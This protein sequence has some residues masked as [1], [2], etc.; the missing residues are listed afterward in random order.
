MKFTA[1]EEYGLRCLI[2]MAREPG[3]LGTIPEIARQEGLTAAYVA[4]LMRVLRRAGLVESVRGQKGGYRLARPPEQMNVGRI[5]ASLGG[6]LYTDD[7][8]DRHAGVKGACVHN[9]DCSMRTL[10]SALD[11]VVQRALRDTTLKD[12]LSTERQFE[13]IVTLRIQ[14]AAAVPGPTLPRY[15]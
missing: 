1:L 8:C 12:L 15:P 3:A 2:Q 11:G 10:W 7:F 5:L 6:R 13:S 4:K 9:I 14:P